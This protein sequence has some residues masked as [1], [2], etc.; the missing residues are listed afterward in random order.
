MKPIIFLPGALG[1][2]AQ[3]DLLRAKMPDRSSVFALDFPGHGGLP[4]ETPFSVSL[5]ADAV[6]QFLE[7]NDFRQVDIFG[8]SM[9]G[10][11]ALWLAWKYPERVRSVI[12]YGTKLDW[13]PEVAAGMSRMFD[14]E[15]IEAKAP[16]L[17][18]KLANTHG[19]LHWKELCRRTAAFLQNL[20]H[21]QGLSAEAFG[22]IQCPVTIGW[23][24]QDNVVTEVESQRVAE[25]IPGGRFVVIPEGKHLLEQVDVRAIVD[26]IVKNC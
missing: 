20:G 17:A 22:A 1:S 21:E 7:E 16:Q 12:T 5:F 15:K 23:G 11:V 13:T 2:A 4:A 24:D 6:L 3:F 26:Y 8:Y 19:E 14:P 18:E 10:Y 9:G 25:A